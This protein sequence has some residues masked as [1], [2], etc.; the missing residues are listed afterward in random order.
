M[1]YETS[2]ADALFVNWAVPAEALPTPPEPLR[3]E[4][5]LEDGVDFGFV[6][7]VLFRQRGLRLAAMPWPRLSFPQCNLRIPVRDEEGAA[8]VW[9]L[10]E[11]VPA[12]VVPLARGL[13]RQPVSAGMFEI[14]STPGGDWRWTIHAGRALSLAARPGA[15]STGRPRLGGWSDTVGFFRDRPRAYVGAPGNRRI[16]TAHPS[17]EGVPMTV[18][19]SVCDWL[20]THLPA[21]DAAL[22][23][24]PHTAFLV[25]SA[26]L[27]FAVDRAPLPAVAAHAPVPG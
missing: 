21:V 23:R 22:W 3:L 12:W 1:I 15:P 7:L 19:P 2:L 6:T 8:G 17:V 25:S 26:R 10:K 9:L 13:G 4:R 18:E 14:R 27:T 11:L 24:A 5:A 20:A 16:E